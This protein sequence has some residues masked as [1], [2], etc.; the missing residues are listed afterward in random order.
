MEAVHKAEDKFSNLVHK[1]STQ[2]DSKQSAMAPNNL[3]KTFKAVVLEKA[4]D[5]FKLRDVPLELPKPGE[6]LIKVHACGVCFSDVAVQ[7]GHMG[8]M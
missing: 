3:P 7:Q 1:S 4:G 5:P 2:Q 6:V 8:P